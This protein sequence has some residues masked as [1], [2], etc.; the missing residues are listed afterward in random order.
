LHNNQHGATGTAAEMATQAW[1]ANNRADWT[2]WDFVNVWEWSATYNLP[3][4]RNVPGEQNP[5]TPAPLTRALTVSLHGGSGGPTFPATIPQTAWAIPATPVPARANYTFG[6]WAL[7]DGG[8][9]VTEIPAG[10]TAAELHALWSAFT[11][12]IAP[13]AI[14]VTAANLVHNLTPGGTA[15][16]DITLTAWSVPLPTGIS[17]TLAANGTTITFADAR[18]AGSPAISGFATVATLTR[19]G[20]TA[21]LDV[22]INLPEIAHTFTIAPASIAVTSANLAHSLTPGGTATG[23]IAITA[24]ATPLPGGITATVTGTTITFA[25]ARP[26]GSP[27]ITNFSS[28]ATLT[29]TGVTAPLA[30]TINLPAVTHTLTLAPAAVTINDAAASATSTAGGTATGAITFNRGTLPAAVQLSYS[31]NVITVTGTRPAAGQPAV[32]GTFSVGVTRNGVTQML[33]V[34]V[35]LTP[36]AAQTVTFNPAATTIND[37]NLSQ[38][39]TVGG[40][41]TGN[42]SINYTG[43]PA[44][45][46]VAYNATAG[47]VTVTG[48]RPTTNVAPVTG[49][50]NISVTRGGVTQSFPVTVNLTTTW[51]APAAF[52]VT[53][54]GSHAT[55]SGAGSFAPGATVTIRAGTRS[56]HSFDAWSSPI[57]VTLAN[58]NNATTTFVMPANNVTVTANWSFSGSGGGGYTRPSLSAPANVRINGTVVS[59]NA[60]NNAGG[61]RVYIGNSPR[62]GIITATS[63]DLATLGLADGTHIVRVRAIYNGS[64][65]DD[66]SLSSR[67]DFRTVYVPVP[68]PGSDSPAPGTDSDSPGTDSPPPNITGLIR[69]TYRYVAVNPNGVILGGVHDTVTGRF[70]FESPLAFTV[71]Y[72]E[73]LNRLILHPD[74]S[75]VIDLAGN[76]PMQF[77][78]VLPI[79]QNGRTLVP[80]RFIGQALG[81]DVLWEDELVH[82]TLD[83]QTLTFP[84]DGTITPEL[85]ALGIDVPPHVLDGRTMMPLRFISEFFGAIVNWDEATGRI[86]II[87]DAGF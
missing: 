1:W 25:D 28:A 35:N 32:T 71:E 53:V 11:F 52:T 80:V 67:V 57:S 14:T 48:V 47:T 34:T 64:R 77:M 37:A 62:S 41:A 43:A 26:A 4:L 84:T 42:I 83:G 5:Q 15:T 69:N 21:T 19:A 36:P 74:S 49:T 22:T 40:T 60:V 18:P 24:W 17:A 54:V 76:A 79:L 50:F 3:V 78:D 82:I 2:G 65:L 44:G 59:W 73:T 70:V 39:V 87:R 46:T 13:A 12:T 66:S 58:M 85:A 56:N 33:T 81:A 23:D 7:T 10:A 38:V 20:A 29:R 86:E 27:A 61:Y 68:G 45:V 72:V 75:F 55:N 16:G 9:P 8:A 30:V 63:F 51:V 31:G 6:G